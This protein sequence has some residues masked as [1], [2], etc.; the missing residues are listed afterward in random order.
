MGEED[1]IGEY[2]FDISCIQINTFNVNWWYI[3][4]DCK[5]YKVTVTNNSEQGKVEIISE[6]MSADSD[7]NAL[8]NEVKSL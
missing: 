3:D 7:K 5:D 2:S 8:I 1:C 6:E 4:F